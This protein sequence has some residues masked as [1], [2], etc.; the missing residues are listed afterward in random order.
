[1]NDGLNLL[2]KTIIPD[3]QFKGKFTEITIPDM[4]KSQYRKM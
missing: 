2:V 4:Y 3:T 1:M